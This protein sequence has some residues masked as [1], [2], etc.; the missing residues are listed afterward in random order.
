MPHM[1]DA[2]ASLLVTLKSIVGESN[3]LTADADVAPYVTDWRERYR[4]RARA[5]VRPGS[6]AE[7][8]AIVRCCA[9]LGVPIVPQGG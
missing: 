4:G 6:T 9:G 5:V 1:F 8:A 7:V 2:A 3:V